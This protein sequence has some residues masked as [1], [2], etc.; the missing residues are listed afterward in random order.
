MPIYAGCVVRVADRVL[1]HQCFASEEIPPAATSPVLWGDLISKCGAP[2][3]R[4]SGFVEIGEPPL[5]LS[6]HVLSDDEIAFA[7]IS[8]EST[9]RRMAHLAL[10]EVNK[11]FKKMFVESPAKL[12]SKSCDVFKVPLQQ[13]MQKFSDDRVHVDE[14]IKKVKQTVEEVKVLAL[15]NVERVLQRGQQIDEIISATDELQVQA[16]GFQRNS[17]ALRT[18]M[19]WNDMKGKMMIGGGVIAFLLIVYFVFCGGVS[20]GSKTS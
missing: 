6:F 18:Q 16:A 10:D 20:C 17:R 3:F 7:L 12:S 8:D 19:W 1:L 14:K 11:L 9:T 15:D 5:R 4:T 13:L 2:N